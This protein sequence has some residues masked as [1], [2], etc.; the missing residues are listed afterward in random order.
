M[1]I[2]IV[3]AGNL[4]GTLA[5]AFRKAG[6]SVIFGVRDA[7]K[8][9]KGKDA[10]IANAISWDNISV[11]VEKSDVVVVSVPAQF[12]HE[13]ARELGDLSNKVVIDTMNAVFQKPGGYSNTGD[14]ILHNS[15]VS[16]LVKCFNSTGFE[17]LADPDYGSIKLDMFMAG[18]SAKAKAIATQLAKDIGFA[19]VYDFGGNDKFFLLEQFA[20]SWINLAILQKQGRDMAFKVIRRKTAV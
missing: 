19:T 6:H 3:G 10:A 15:N 20:F 11:A 4:G 16:D 1:N 12:A 18:D 2:A 7:Q 9:F 14:A 8:N 17:N 13:V 5:P